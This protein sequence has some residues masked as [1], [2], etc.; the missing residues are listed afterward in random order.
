MHSR[1]FIF[2]EYQVTSTQV[3]MMIAEN[4]MLMI[5]LDSYKMEHYKPIGEGRKQIK[6]GPQHNARK[7]KQRRW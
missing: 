1:F 6:H 4:E 3:R 7:G 2:N 5:E